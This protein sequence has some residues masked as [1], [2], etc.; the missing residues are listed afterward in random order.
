MHTS[1]WVKST[2]SSNEE[3]YLGT[4]YTLSVLSEGRPRVVGDSEVLD[5]SDPWDFN[6]FYEDIASGLYLPTLYSNEVV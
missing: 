3:V 6:V 4:D 2:L 5:C 1:V